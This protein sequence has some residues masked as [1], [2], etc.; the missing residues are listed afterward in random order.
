MKYFRI[1]AL[2]AR[3]SLLVLVCGAV[4][5]SRAATH[6][7]SQSQCENG[8]VPK[9]EIAISCR[10][11]SEPAPASVRSSEPWIMLNRVALSFKST[12]EN[13]ML[14]EITLSSAPANATPVSRPVYLSVDRDDGSNQVRRLLPDVHLEELVF[15]KPRTF[16]Q[17]VLV[18]VF[19]PG[20]YVVHLWIPSADPA[21]TF[22]AAHNL[23]LRSIGVPDE[24]TRLNRIADFTITR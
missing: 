3:T 5:S 18:G 10:Y 12:D 24:Q 11:I 8:Q 21:Y 6:V 9:D 1:A 7:S 2:V 13:Y 17:R 19:Q 22:D 20:H 15:G 23:L 4:D 14:V 16:S